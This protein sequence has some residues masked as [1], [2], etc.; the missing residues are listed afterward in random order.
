MQVTVDNG[1]R[2]LPEERRPRF[3]EQDPPAARFFAVLG[4][5]RKTGLDW[6]LQT[7]SE[8]IHAEVVAASTGARNNAMAQAIFERGPG[9]YA[10]DFT[11]RSAMVDQPVLVVAGDADLTV[12]SQHTRFAY[13]RKTEVVLRGGHLAF[14]ESREAFALAVARFARASAVPER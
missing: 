3:G 12:G 10:E 5:L 7:T 9:S 13:P 14:Y 8:K 11:A 6:R 4:A 2:Q 1:L